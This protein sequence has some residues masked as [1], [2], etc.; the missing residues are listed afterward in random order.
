M[1]SASCFGGFNQAVPIN[2]ASSSRQARRQPATLL[3]VGVDSPA[4]GLE[5]VIFLPPKLFSSVQGHD[6]DIWTYRL[7]YHLL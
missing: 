7:T 3:Q 5:A 2:S 4:Q 6:K 1:D